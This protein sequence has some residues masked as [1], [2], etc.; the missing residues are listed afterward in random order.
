MSNKLYQIDPTPPSLGTPKAEDAKL[1]VKGSVDADRSPRETKDLNGP[2]ELEAVGE[3]AIVTFD[4]AAVGK[5]GSESDGSAK[6]SEDEDDLSEALH[7]ELNLSAD[8]ESEMKKVLI[9][10]D[11]NGTL[12]FR[13]KDSSIRNIKA[14][15]RV[16]HTQYFIRP[17]AREL[18]CHLVNDPRCKVYNRTQFNITSWPFTRVS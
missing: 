6:D 18:V 9:L 2:K 8:A 13:D 16:G 11:F 5:S 12:V 7:R 1:S 3:K 14:D 4:A 10:L 17:F 15:Y